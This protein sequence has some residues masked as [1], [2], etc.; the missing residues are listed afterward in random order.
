MDLSSIKKDA[1][2]I[3][4]G[5][6]FLYRSYYAL[7][8]LHT[9]L[10]K[11]THATFA[12]CRT[13]SKLI[14]DFD[15]KKIV[16]AWD[17]KSS[18]AT[19]EEVYA[20]YK[21]TRQAAPSDLFEQ[22]EDIVNFIELI[23]MC[24][25]SKDS[26]EADDLIASLVKEHPDEQIV[27]VCADKDMYQLLANDHVLILDTFK[28][29]LVSKQD[30]ITEHGFGPE[31]IPFFYA[32]TGD[33]SDNIP[34]VAGVGKKTAEDLV[35]G[36]D[37]LEDLYNNLDKVEKKRTQ[38]LLSEQKDNALLS[39]KLFLPHYTQTGLSKKD[40]DFDKQH[41]NK[42]HD[43]FEELNFRAF[44]KDPN[45][46]TPEKKSSKKVAEAQQSMFDSTAQTW[47]CVI[48]SSIEQL[49]TLLAK[50]E[51]TGYCG[52]DTETS[53][54]N[55]LQD[56][57]V[58][59]SF[60]YDHA[61][62]YYIPLRH[63]HNETYPQIPVDE[64]LALI[65]P[66]LES[67]TIEKYLHNTKFDELVFLN[68]GITPR[69][70]TFDTLIAANLLRDAWQ[71]I[72]LKNLSL[73]YLNEPMR[74]FKEVMGKEYKSFNQVPIENGAEYGAHDALQT[75]KL[76]EI[77]EKQLAQEPVLKKIFDEI[78]MPLYHVL[79]KMEHKGIV[80][81]ADI[82]RITGKEVEKELAHLEEK[83]FAA[84]YHDGHQMSIGSEAPINL[85]SPKQIETL[86]FETLGL[87]SV[88]K[89]KGGSKSTD[90]EVLEK[91]SKI[92]PIPG[93]ILRHRELAKLKNTYL[94]PL[95]LTINPTTHRVHTSYSQTMAA[96]GRLSSNNPNLQNIPA[97]SDYGFK[98]RSA[99]VA[100]S[101]HSFIAADYSQ[102]E[103]RVLAHLSE[104][105]NLIEAFR[106]GRDIHTQTA[107]QLFDVAP[108]LV[109]NEQ[110]QIGKKINFSIIY[111][112]SAYGLSQELEIS[113]TE[114]KKYIETYFAQYPKVKTWME[115]VIEKTLETGYVETWWG[116]RRYVPELAEKN[117]I[118]HELGRRIA[119][120]TAVQGTAADIMK[121]AMIKLDQ[122]FA[123][124]KMASCLILQIHDELVLEAPEHELSEAKSMV[125]AIMQEVTDWKIPLD[126]SVKTGQN[127]GQITK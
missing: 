92:H 65:K 53:G 55:P 14:K 83:L 104:D 42:A 16:V 58:G 71:K 56:V 117:K 70:T 45:A 43:F 60:A 25:V 1:L 94:D 96:T 124:K 74:K 88:K 97:S 19:R 84:I 3:I 15:P 40:L 37:S 18:T 106:Q 68:N 9:P 99:F 79:T 90:H 103:L 112:K 93:L 127:W 108:D 33:A 59:I 89:N 80:L 77:F 51:K 46:Q 111:G 27:I 98:I 52:L 126:V 87:P 120:N 64:C 31:K 57:L 122:A 69:G 119:V 6:Y 95:P 17:S 76:K 115:S 61:R 21:A 28:N 81:D 4:D 75:L 47:E 72:N 67:D 24:N 22:K 35:K 10:G 12:F 39:L 50:I 30:F 38:T 91:L 85:N 48:V 2:F 20:E 62:A 13:I 107:A 113:A 114:A 7:P 82:L 32:L 66:L 78:E 5:S 110:R 121:I 118:R 36:F 49:K 73:F 44:L 116:K 105:E 34:G 109:T 63:P 11:P 26:F 102:I 23:N 86:L 29:K 100:P 101:G 123:A 8:P 41:W 125:L 54:S